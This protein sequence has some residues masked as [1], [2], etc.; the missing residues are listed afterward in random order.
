MNDADGGVKCCMQDISF[1]KAGSGLKKEKVTLDGTQAYYY[2]HGRDTEEYDSATKRLQR[3]EQYIVAYMDKL[4][5]KYPQKTR[6][7]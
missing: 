7:R 1:P 3:E 6:I 2:L 4:K 5:K